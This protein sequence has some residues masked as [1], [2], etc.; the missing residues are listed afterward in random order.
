MV[1]PFERRSSRVVLETPIFRLRE[2]VATHPVTGHTGAYVVLESP[3]WVN[4]VAVTESG[5]ILMVRQWRH[6]TRSVEL[7]IPAG[8]VDEGEAPLEAAARELREETGYEASQWVL[9]GQVRPNCAYQSNTCYTAL[10]LG[11][12]K[13]HEQDLDPGED[14]EVVTVTVNEI[15][16]LFRR[17]ELKNGMVI[18]GLMWWLDHKG[19][20]D[21]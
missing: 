10:A 12:K 6:G 4:M 21:W 7:E 14:I 19:V 5:E 16:D 9:I 1:E 17:G 18:C 20:I 11:C 15:R 3:D 8:L 13:V 2:D